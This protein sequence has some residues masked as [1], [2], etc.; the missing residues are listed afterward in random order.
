[1]VDTMD[2]LTFLYGALKEIEDETPY[3]ISLHE[4]HR[5]NT[6][7]GVHLE[8]GHYKASHESTE[9]SFPEIRQRLLKQFLKHIIGQINEP[10][11]H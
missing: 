8:I 11:N 1:M 5:K 6:L 4:E 2:G 10:N 7:K 3:N 9:L